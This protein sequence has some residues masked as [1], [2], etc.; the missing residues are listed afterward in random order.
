MTYIYK[1]LKK[2]IMNLT[3]G[4][5]LIILVTVSMTVGLINTGIVL[6]QVLDS[7]LHYIF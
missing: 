5:I 7:I 6:L 2:T 3:W 4:S 1:F